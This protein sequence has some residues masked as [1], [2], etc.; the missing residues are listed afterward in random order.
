[1]ALLNLCHCVSKI[2]N[3]QRAGHVSVIL[4]YC[5]MTHD[6]LKIIVSEGYLT[7]VQIIEERDGIKSMKVDL[8][9]FGGK[10][11]IRSFNMISRPGLRVQ[12]KKS[13]LSSFESI[14]G[15]VLISTNQGLMTL[16]EAIKLGCGG[17]LLCRLA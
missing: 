2:K 14:M 17:E 10:G 1:M 8:K 12:C 9:Y 11:V 5:G 7:D 13:E 15:L 4:K 16:K 6:I 3:A